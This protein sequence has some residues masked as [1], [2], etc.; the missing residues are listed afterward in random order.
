MN[1]KILISLAILVFLSVGS[2]VLADPYVIEAWDVTNLTQIGGI[3]NGNDNDLA[4]VNTL[5]G[6]SLT[7]AGVD[8]DGSALSGPTGSTSGY[9]TW[10]GDGIV[11][12]VLVKAGNYFVVY[13]LT[14]YLDNPGDSQQ[15]IQ[16]VIMNNPG[17]A[18]LGISHVTGYN[19][20]TS[21]PEPATLM[22]LG[23]GLVAV[24]LTKKFTS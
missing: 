15:I 1:K 6:L 22:L 20:G 21:V 9:F 18:Y 2:T 16:N 11:T 5:T 17:N 10:N 23:I 4:N 14:N 13:S 12:H 19:G 8:H 24:P 7:W 3:Y